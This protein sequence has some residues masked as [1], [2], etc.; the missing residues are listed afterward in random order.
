MIP[1]KS[2][3]VITGGM[4]PGKKWFDLIKGRFDIV[5]AADSGYN[6]A[7]EIGAKIDFVVGDMDSIADKSSL[8]DFPVE[9][10]RRFDQDKD[11]T[12]TELGLQLLDEKK[13]N[14]KGIF[15]GGGGR[16]DHLYGIFSLFDRNDS[17]DIWISDT[18]VV[19]N[20][21]DSFTLSEMSGQTISFFPLGEYRCTMTS[22]GLKWALDHV[23]WKKGCV[24][25]SNLVISD[26]VEITMQ[27]GRLAFVGELATLKGMNL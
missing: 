6:T 26:N 7:I 20:I 22:K 8:D 5:V 4:A 2:G 14:F 12:D 1:S 13:C 25:I 10:I 17:P 9:S 19:V 24:G 16:R 27:T 15:G 3:L 11:F 23:E 21:F 18:A